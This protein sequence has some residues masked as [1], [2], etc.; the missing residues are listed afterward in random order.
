[1][2][3]SITYLGYDDSKNNVI[4]KII[5]TEFEQELQIFEG[6]CEFLATMVEYKRRNYSHQEIV[7][8][9]F[10][11]NLHLCNRYKSSFEHMLDWQSNYIDK[12]FKDINFSKL[13]YQD[14]KN[15]W[16]KHKVFI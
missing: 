4:Y 6:A 16:D 12:S 7:K 14:I 13:Y 8:N 9:L 5:D 11:C 15:M 2:F 3:K 10:R 1:M